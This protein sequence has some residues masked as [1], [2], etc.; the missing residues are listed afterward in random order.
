MSLIDEKKTQTYHDSHARLNHRFGTNSLR[1]CKKNEGY[2][3]ITLK[4]C[5]IY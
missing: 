2:E 5:L 3:E 4:G 1:L